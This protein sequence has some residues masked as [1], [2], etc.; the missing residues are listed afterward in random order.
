MLIEKDYAILKLVSGENIIC[1]IDGLKED[2]IL[3]HKPMV[4]VIQGSEI[5]LMLYMPFSKSDDYKFFKDTIICQGD[6]EEDL[7]QGYIEEISGLKMPPKPK[8]QI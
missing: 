4:I 2:Y 7:K 8:F 6:V 3:V 1:R 5:G